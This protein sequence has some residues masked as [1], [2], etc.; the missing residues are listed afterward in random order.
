M[1]R[2]RGRC[3]FSG[4]PGNIGGLGGR[5]DRILRGL[6]GRALR[7]QLFAEAFQIGMLV[8]F[9]GNV[10][11]LDFDEWIIDILAWRRA[12]GPSTAISRLARG[13]GHVGGEAGR[14]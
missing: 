7:I 4:W 8:L 2:R 12:A 1:V 14:A 6:V 13:G 10:M 11:M 5:F 9:F 3:G